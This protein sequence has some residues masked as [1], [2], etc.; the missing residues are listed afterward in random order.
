[1]TSRLSRVL[2]PFAANL[3]TTLDTARRTAILW[4]LARLMV[5]FL[6]LL[7]GGV[8]SGRVATGEA[9]RIMAAASVRQGIGLAVVIL[10]VL[11]VADVG[12]AHER[13]FLGNLGIGRRHVAAV[14][15]VTAALLEVA[16]GL[17]TGAA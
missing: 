6:N 14:A 13:A 16:A 15:L 5:G 12:L 10:P 7:S 3:P 9:A 8:A 11:V 4:V 2:D 1:M 17:L